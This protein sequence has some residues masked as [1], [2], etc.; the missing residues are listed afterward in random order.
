MKKLSPNIDTGA[1]M[2]HTENMHFPF[3]GGAVMLDGFCSEDK[4]EWYSVND[5]HTYKP[6]SSSSDDNCSDTTVTDSDSSNSYDTLEDARDYYGLPMSDDYCT[7]GSELYSPQNVYNSSQVLSVIPE[8]HL[9]SGMECE[10]DALQSEHAG[11]T[12]IDGTTCKLQAENTGAT[13]ELQAKYSGVT[14]IDAEL[15]AEHSG[16]TYVQAKHSGA[17]CADSELQ[18]KDCGTTYVQAK[19]SGT[20]CADSELQAKH[21]GAICIDGDLKAKHSGTTCVQEEHSGATCET[22][23]AKNS[24]DVLSTEIN[25]TSKSTIH[26]P[27][28]EMLHAG[29]FRSNVSTDL[30][31]MTESE[32][33]EIRERFKMHQGQGDGADYIQCTYL[34]EDS[35]SQGCSAIL[36]T[37][38]PKTIETTKVGTMTAQHE[39]EMI[40]F[41]NT[42]GASQIIPETPPVA[43]QKPDAQDETR[44][45]EMGVH[46]DNTR[47]P[48]SGS[49]KV[50]ETGP[51]GAQNVRCEVEMLLCPYN[52]S[53]SS[54]DTDDDDDNDT[55]TAGSSSASSSDQYVTM[56]TDTMGTTS[57]ASSYESALLPGYYT[58]LVAGQVISLT[59]VQIS[60]SEQ[61]DFPDWLAKFRTWRSKFPD[62][63]TV[64]GAWPGE[65]PDWHTESFWTV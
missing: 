43:V 54:G 6:L 60:E 37:P 7:S 32:T 14:C 61:S 17:M 28:N 50:R 9:E 1:G 41:L 34:A 10:N 46:L 48:S 56:G 18:A 20:T 26:G 59:G 36:Q 35:K 63:Y 12:C 45:I 24:S 8:V 19:H 27:D 3:E 62:W 38:F 49:E 31:N 58:G 40:I 15:Q 65:Y 16:A 25:C 42:A 23:N 33:D 4:F 52:T 44:V 64:F 5:Y 13:C 21:C 57:G 51:L 55:T 30:R 2:E 39:S 29:D 53:R 47:R 11:A 22:F